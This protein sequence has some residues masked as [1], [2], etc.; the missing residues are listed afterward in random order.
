MADPAPVFDL[1]L[2]STSLY[3]LA[4]LERLGVPFRCEAPRVNEEALK[5]GRDDPRDLAAY[6]ARCKA[7][8]LALLWPDATI[9]GGDQVVACDGRIL[10]KPG[11]EEAAV[12]QLAMLA[13]RAHRLITALAVWHGG[14]FFEHTDETVLWMRPLDRAALARYVA[15]D[16]PTDCAGSYKLE[17][18]GIVLFEKI[19]SGDQTAITGMPLIALTTVLRGLG[20]PIP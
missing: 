14:W 19:E 1:V 17:A 18:R 4:L 20:F 11:G 12:D 2:A 8:S 15:A 3:R 9:I 7:A 16:R 10:G 6:L 13:G 5:A